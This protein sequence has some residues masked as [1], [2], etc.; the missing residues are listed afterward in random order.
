MLH[1]KD[2]TLQNGSFLL[3]LDLPPLGTGIYAMIGP[4]GG[5]K[6]T[7]LAAIAGFQPLSAGQI[8]WQGR[9][10][11]K[12]LPAKRPV[13]ILFQDNNL[14][15][16]LSIERNV[17]LA[18]SHHNSLT[19]DEKTKVSEALV[20]VGLKAHSAKKPAELS[21]GQQSRAALARILLQDKPIL[22]LDE[23]FSALGPALR[24]DMLGLVAEIA[25]ESKTTV[26]MVTHTVSDARLIAEETVFID[27]GKAELPVRTNELLENPTAAVKQYLGND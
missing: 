25:S 13:A 27:N 20:R 21:G 2:V 10:I 16:H 23:P 6:S 1:I 11:S 15:P 8:L 7:A 19:Q 9:D 5:G 4:S 17:A 14:F 12:A 22:L 24:R 26:I 3:S 18:L